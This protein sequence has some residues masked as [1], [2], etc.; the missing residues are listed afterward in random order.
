MS[1]DKL[2]PP[3][4]AQ[5]NWKQK[6]AVE[7]VLVDKLRSDL[8]RHHGLANHPK[9]GLLWSLAWD[10]GHAY[11]ANEIKSHYDDLAGLLK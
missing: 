1:K 10:L 7:R 5:E 3:S 11:G 4:N 8:E 6:A 9:A 2:K